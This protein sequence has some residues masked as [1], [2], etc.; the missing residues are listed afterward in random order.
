MRVYYGKNE[1]KIPILAYH[2]VGIPLRV[3]TW[4]YLTIPYRVFE[5]H[6]QLLFNHGYKTITLSDLVDIVISGRTIPRK[7]IV[8]T[9]DDGYLDNWVF[10]FPILKKYHFKA[11]FFIPTDFVDP[12][13]VMRETLIDTSTPSQNYGFMSWEE[14]RAMSEEG[15][16]IQSHT[17]T[18]TWYFKCD[19]VIDFRTENNSYF[20]IDWNENSQEKYKYFEKLINKE[21]TMWLWRPIYR[22]SEA[23]TTKRYFPDQNFDYMLTDYVK[24]MVGG[25]SENY[26]ISKERVLRQVRRLCQDYNPVGKYESH[27]EYLS[28][29]ENEINSS[30]K[31]IESNIKERVTVLCW[32]NGAYNSQALLSAQKAGY[33]A[34]SFSFKS[35]RKISFTDNQIRFMRLYPPHFFVGSSCKYESGL[36]FILNIALARNTFIHKLYGVTQSLRGFLRRLL[37]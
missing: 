3:W 27:Q 32:P 2:S 30:K 1:F 9:F 14:L 19:E 34:S 18:H 15:M 13:R 17:A 29:I 31:T 16:D 12:R 11:T 6:V 36:N 26:V 20:W 35:E 10:A 4:K 25:K 5:S 7:T 22:F 8:L 28:R 33:L 23:I 37:E 21:K 24:K